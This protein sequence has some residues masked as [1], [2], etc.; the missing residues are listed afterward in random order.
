MELEYDE[1]LE[2]YFIRL[3]DSILKNLDWEEGDYLDYEFDDDGTI[4]IFKV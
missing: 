4:R 1:E 2:E 3:S